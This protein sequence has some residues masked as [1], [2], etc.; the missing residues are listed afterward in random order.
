MLS[1]INIENLEYSHLESTA[2]PAHILNYISSTSCHHGN[3]CPF[4][5][6]HA[7]AG[8]GFEMKKKVFN[9]S[10]LLI[11]MGNT[12]CIFVYFSIGTEATLLVDGETDLCLRC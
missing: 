5:S 6:V 1:K 8:L 9:E 7:N 10:K 11:L 2:S 4:N 12:H 3:S